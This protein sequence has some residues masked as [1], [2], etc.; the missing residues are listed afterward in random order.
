[1]TETE[2]DLRAVTNTQIDPLLPGGLELMA[3]VEASVTERVGDASVIVERLGPEAAVMTATVVANFQMMNRVADA[4]GIPV[5]TGSRQ[6]NADLI[7]EL[8]L[9]RFDHLD[10]NA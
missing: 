8:D 10:D 4:T 1:M 6:R 3:F 2:V 9:E 5:G 7:A